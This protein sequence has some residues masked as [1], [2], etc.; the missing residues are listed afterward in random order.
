[1]STNQNAVTGGGK[2]RRENIG[3]YGFLNDLAGV[4]LHWSE[5][6][7]ELTIKSSGKI[8]LP[9]GDQIR[10]LVIGL[11]NSPAIVRE[12]RNELQAQ[13]DRMFARATGSK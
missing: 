13:L 11:K 5:D 9:F 2:A 8:G 7:R 6:M 12:Q 10:Q 1:M 4:S 3:D